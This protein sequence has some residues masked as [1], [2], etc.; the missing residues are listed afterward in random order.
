MGGPQNKLRHVCRAIKYMSGKSRRRYRL[1]R[2]RLWWHTQAKREKRRERTVE[3]MGL[4][5][6]RE[7]VD[8]GFETKWER[9][10]RD[11]RNQSTSSS[12]AEGRAVCPVFVVRRCSRGQ[13]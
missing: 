3:R 13:T 2:T 1:V 4:E 12:L 7:G 5:R 10:E 6:G 11:P 9:G 8:G